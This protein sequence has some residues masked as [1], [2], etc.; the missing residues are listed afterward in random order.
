MANDHLP[1][2]RGLRSLP[3]R[4]PHYTDFLFAR[5]PY[6]R[7][8][9]GTIDARLQS[10]VER[11][12]LQYVE[13][14]GA[15]GIN[16]ASAL[17][18]DHRTMHVLALVGSADYENSR[19]QGQVDGT[20][21]LRSPGSA[22]KPFLYGLAADQGLI[23][24]SSVLK[25]TPLA[26][27]AYNPENFDGDF[28]GPIKA[29]DALVRSRNLPAIQIANQLSPGMHDFLKRAGIRK[30]Q[31]EDYYGL[32]LTLGG[33]EVSMR[34][35]AA[36]YAMLANGGTL[37]NLLYTKSDSMT[38]AVRLLS[39]EASFIV[40]EMLRSNPRPG[41]EFN[42]RWTRDYIPVHWKTGTS[43]GFRDA[44][45]AGVFGKYVLVVWVGNFDGSSNPAF[46]GREAA[47][48]LFFEIVDA[49]KGQGHL[50]S[51]VLA[52]PPEGVRKID[53][54]ALSG[55]LPGPHCRHREKSWFIPGKS[56]I[57]TCAIHREVSV[58]I[59]SGLRACRPHEPGTRRVV[60]EFWSS[61][62]IELFKISGISRRTPPPYAPHCEIRDEF[63]FEPEIVSPQRRV[64]YN[65][66]GSSAE[67]GIPLSAVIDA[68][69]RELFWFENS[70]FLGKV[71]RGEN[72]FWHP[73]P[74]NYLLRVV[75]D[76]GRASSRDVSVKLAGTAP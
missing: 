11:Q 25:D 50:E 17:L 23:H 52:I 65:V 22:L 43:F 29:H 32:A 39:P 9:N 19:I 63:G 12:I 70:T 45:A 54:C 48:P 51:N 31:D 62:L 73:K 57:H 72:Y 36:L 55:Q 6:E 56:P 27:A 53:V 2:F 49:L 75:D 60:H 58:Y 20:R 61:D 37:Q 30:L 3:F 38:R 59:E 10:L 71:R 5:S 21:A 40:M 64:I 4:A 28:V 1:V 76:L 34:D 42:E 46:K 67:G 69:A 44:W 14:Q 68:D 15:R 16:N 18:L 47:G 66:G 8:V 7:Q 33:V 13:R 74:G 41:S 26:Y 35:L 24:S